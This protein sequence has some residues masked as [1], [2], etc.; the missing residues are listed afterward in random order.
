MRTF[1]RGAGT[2]LKIPAGNVVFSEGDPA[3]C[4][5]IVQ[6]GEIEILIN[7]KVVDLCGPNEAL[8]F[9][10][11]I[12]GLPRTSTARVKAAAEL[13]IIDKRTFR[14][15]VDE[16]PNFAHYIMEVMAH[17]IRGMRQAI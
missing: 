11:V 3:D 1:A 2:T 12:D 6:E 10:A 17:R 4:L 15:M 13:S 9:M 14:F 7:N 8:G 16:V 5:Y